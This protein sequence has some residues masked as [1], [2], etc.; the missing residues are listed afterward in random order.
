VQ[1]LAAI[2]AYITTQDDA[3][4]H[5]TNLVAAADPAAGTSIYQHPDLAIVCV[6]AAIRLTHFQRLMH[7]EPNDTTLQN[8]IGNEQV[9]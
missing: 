1:A 9:L 5:V 7:L 2:K 4:V 3:L 8:G 6:K